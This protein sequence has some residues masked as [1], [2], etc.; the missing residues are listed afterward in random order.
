[1]SFC[2]I[3]DVDS[4]R[5]PATSR[6]AACITADCFKYTDDEGVGRLSS[7]S[8][9]LPVNTGKEGNHTNTDALN[10]MASSV[11]PFS[12]NAVFERVAA[13]YVESTS[14]C[15]EYVRLCLRMC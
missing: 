6:L 1:M 5:H 2:F 15:I 8:P 13:F 12:A 11:V 3:V 14:I 9:G 7:S 4:L 10:S